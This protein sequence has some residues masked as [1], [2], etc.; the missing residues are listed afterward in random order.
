VIALIR[1]QTAFAARGEGFRASFVGFDWVRF[2]KH[3]V[4]RTFLNVPE[5][6]IP[7]DSSERSSAS[8]G[9][10]CIPGK[11]W[12][13]PGHSGTFWDIGGRAERATSLLFQLSKSDFYIPR[14]AC[15]FD[16]GLRVE[17]SAIAR[18][19]AEIA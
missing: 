16:A 9:S 11:S 4:R 17:F 6:R 7:R 19:S 10:F 18:F 2:P 14:R 15:A 12:G 13:I 3:V 5:H 8:V 1:A